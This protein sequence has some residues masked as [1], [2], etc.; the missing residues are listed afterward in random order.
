MGKGQLD[1]SSF[2]LLCV[3]L[4]QNRLHKENGRPIFFESP[5]TLWK[6]LI[7]HAET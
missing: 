5:L 3:N 6:I 7:V 1:G 4:F 2:S